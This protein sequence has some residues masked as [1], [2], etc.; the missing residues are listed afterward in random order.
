VQLT[1]DQILSATGGQLA[2]G[3]GETAV[4]SISTDTRSLETG[5]VFFAL[6]T[7]EGDGHAFLQKAADGGAAVLVVSNGASASS[8]MEYDGAVVIVADTLRSLGDLA[9]WHRRRLDC[10]VVAVTGSC[11]KSS[12]KEMIGQVLESGRRGHRAEASFNNFI[13]VPLTILRSQVGDDYLIVEVGTSAPG[14]IR[15]LAEIARPDIA[16]VT[17]VE[18][19]HLEGLGSLDGIAAEKEDLVRSLSADGVAVL[20]A[21]DPRVAAMAEAAGHVVTFGVT[22][23][24]LLAHDVQTDAASVTFVLD[25]GVDVRLPVPGRHNVL[26]ALAAVAVAREFG[27]DDAT[28]AAALARYRPLEMRL[29]RE[30]LPG[31]VTLLD[32]CYNANPASA[33]VALD[34]LCDQP[35]DKRRVLVQGDMLELGTES[36]ALHEAF[37]HAVSESCVTTLVTVGEA[38]RTTS[39]AASEREDLVRFHFPD[40]QGAADEVPSLL[41]SGDVIL[42][43]GSRGIGLEVVCEAVRSAFG[44]PPAG[45]GQ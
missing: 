27:L 35:T 10:R 6:V 41:G 14:E 13:G 33:R 38:T 37:G 4:S 43:K 44:S 11:G 8:L 12:V 9:A 34:V 40:A 18:P 29:V 17:G 28:I 45:G 2:A 39:M 32:D 3:T 31:G 26:N 42:V 21:D 30:Q 7:E 19:V 22:D 1:V 25:A 15:R 20:N 16:V 24:S 23:G 5:A 36:D